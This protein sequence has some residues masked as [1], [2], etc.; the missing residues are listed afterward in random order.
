MFNVK[1]GE[2]YKA[3][4][5]KIS[6]SDGDVTIFEGVGEMFLLV[7]QSGNMM[8]ITNAPILGQFLNMAKLKER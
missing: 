6:L 7:Q 5:L 8:L 1:Y 4:D 3:R 2:I